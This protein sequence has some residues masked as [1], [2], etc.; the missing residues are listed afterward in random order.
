MFGGPIDVN[1]IGGGLTVGTKDSGFVKLKA[2]PRIGVLVKQL[3]Y[4]HLSTA[5]VNVLC[6][7]TIHVS[8]FQTAPRCPVEEVR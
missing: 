5:P 3:R 1:H 2:W 7:L 6:R 4:G 8:N